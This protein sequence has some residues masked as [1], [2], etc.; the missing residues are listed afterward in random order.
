MSCIIEVAIKRHTKHK[1]LAEVFVL[2]ALLC[3]VAKAQAQTGQ[4]PLVSV[5][6]FG[7]PPVARQAS[8]TLRERLRSSG[9]LNVADADLSRAAAKGI[10]YS[11]S[12]NLTA[13]EARDLGA[14]L[15][16]EFFIIGDAQTL[17]RS[18]FEAP[19]YYESYCSI[20]LVS[21]RTGKLIFW[22]RTSFENSEATRAE[23]QLSQHLS[24]DAFTRRLI[25]VTRKAHEDERM[26]RT[27]LP[28]TAEVVIEEAPEDEKTAEVQGVRLP[29]PYRRLRPD[30]PDTAAR[31]EAEATVDV[32]VDVGADGEVGEVQVVRW[33]GF[34]LDESTV[35]TVRQLHFFPAMRNGTPIPMRV[36]L[37]YN[38]RKPPR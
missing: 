24:G 29:R 17:R 4:R 21:A 25:A 31:A 37:R 15:A 10:G 32:V 27:V 12:L 9:E 16:T 22:D 19:V 8:D 1:R 34:G 2:L 23:S 28:N 5:L 30:Y 36:L 38:F 35:A 33:A 26:Q 14:A 13:S 20:F 3:G 18:S 11:G 7:A 6:D